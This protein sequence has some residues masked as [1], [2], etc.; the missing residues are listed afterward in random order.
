MQSNPITQLTG[1]LQKVN[2]EK[3]IAR[4][5]SLLL[6]EFKKLPSELTGKTARIT[7]KIGDLDVDL[8]LKFEPEPID[9]LFELLEFLRYKAEEEKK[10]LKRR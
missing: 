10:A 1:L 6:Y 7:G 8:E 4:A 5:I 3:N 9:S 2:K